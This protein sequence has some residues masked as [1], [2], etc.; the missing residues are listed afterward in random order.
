MMHIDRIAHRAAE[1]NVPEAQYNLG[2]AYE[3]GRGLSK[4]ETLAIKWYRAAVEAG[5]ESV[6]E[7]LAEL[8]G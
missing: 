1:R 4:D 7:R 5:I 3:L 2:L 8:G 6:A